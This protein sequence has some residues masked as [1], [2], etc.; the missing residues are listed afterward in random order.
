MITT[1]NRNIS[2]SKPR[3]PLI[4]QLLEVILV[5]SVAELKFK[6]LVCSKFRSVLKPT[7]LNQI[8]TTSI[9][10]SISQKET[11]F[12]AFFYCNNL[13]FISI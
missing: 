7:K 6:Y 5:V 10:N 9:I 3:A 4:T 11:N 12:S 8:D 1:I 13:I 2:N